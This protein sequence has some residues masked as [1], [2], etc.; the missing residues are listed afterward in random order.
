MTNQKASEYKLT[1]Y[2]FVIKNSSFMPSDSYDHKLV[3]DDQNN[4]IY[5]NLKTLEQRKIFFG[6]L[7]NH[8]DD[9]TKEKVRA[10]ELSYEYFV[11][12]VQSDDKKI[13]F[14]DIINHI[15]NIINENSL[16]GLSH[17]FKVSNEWK[18][19]KVTVTSYDLAVLLNTEK[20]CVPYRKHKYINVKTQMI[21]NTTE[22]EMA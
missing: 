1:N 18:N 3:K 6:D 15:R 2:S 5:V 17:C 9:T 21:D 11:R 12:S 14:N 10:R 22:T 8:N 20:M 19:Y 13:S 7:K 16:S 4:K